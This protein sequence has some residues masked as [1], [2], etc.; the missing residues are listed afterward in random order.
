MKL[1]PILLSLAAC[2]ILAADPLGIERI[3]ITD[4]VDDGDAMILDSNQSGANQSFG[5]K[6]IATLST[7]AN[8][9]PYSVIAYSPSVNFTPVDQAGSNEPSY[10]DP[11]RIRGKSQSGPGGV[12]MIDGMPI[13]SNPGGGKQLVDMENVSSI[14]LLKGYLPADK[15]LGFSSLIGKVDLNL[16][17]AKSKAGAEVSQSFGSDNFQRTFVRFD[18]G[19][20]G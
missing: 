12:Y 7:Q 9:N 19:K 15:N 20:I 8:M 1:S 16:L 3:V 5:T 4:T 10:H 2:S 14:D 6:S 17:S 18:S 11:I 13:S